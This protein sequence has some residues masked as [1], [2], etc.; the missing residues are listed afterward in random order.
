MYNKIYPVF[1]DNKEIV[2]LTILRQDITKEKKAEEIKN[3]LIE[4]LSNEREK[5]EKKNQELTLLT[6]QHMAALE[7]IY[8]KNEELKIAYKAKS[9]FIANVSHELK[10]PLNIIMTY[11]E[12]LLEEEEGELNIIQKDMLQTAYNNSDRLKHLISDLLDLSTIETDKGKFNFTSIGV[13]KFISSLIKDRSILIKDKDTNIAF[14]PLMNEVYIIAD[15]LR[16]RQVIDNIIDNAIKFSNEGDI[17][18]FIEEIENYIEIY[19]K[20]YGIGIE[21]EKIE[22]IFKP[23]YQ[24][25]DSS[26]KKYKGVGLGLSIVKRII[27]ALGG[28]ISI[29]NNYDKGCTFKITIPDD[30][31]AKE[32][33]NEENIYS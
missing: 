18:I 17:E 10:T 2:K 20:D 3:T 30:C 28:N 22:D 8:T 32:E 1:N 11:L 27:Q 9:N 15:E 21:Q 14:N 7:S 12:Y 24:I 31:S 19:I 25:D 29:K 4:E 26:K 23:F 6:E 16:L 33:I 5:L 13:N